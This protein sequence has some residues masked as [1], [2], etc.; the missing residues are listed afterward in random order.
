MA[1]IRCTRLRR[2][3]GSL[4]GV[5]FATLLAVSLAG[6]PTTNEFGGVWRPVETDGKLIYNP[7]TGLPTL[8]FELV[9]EHYGPDIAGLIR[10]HRNTDYERTRDPTTPFNECA[11]IY[12][13]KGRYGDKSKSYEFITVGCLP[14]VAS[15][16]NIPTRG[17]L[18]LND[19]GQLVGTL[20]VDDPTSAHDGKVQNMVL[21]RQAAA[22]SI[23]AS[24]F[25]C[26]QPVDA[27]AGNIHS[28]R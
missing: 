10:F 3:G 27:D 23:L 15:N 7:E 19:D 28:G 14:G 20:R 11:C 16:A 24:D 17:L 4:A 22:G 5:A 8:G 13:H 2:R 1:A 26:E 12:M 6:C 9:M 21:E 25:L 18:T